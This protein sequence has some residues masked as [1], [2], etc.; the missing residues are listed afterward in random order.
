MNECSSRSHLVVRLHIESRPVD[1]SSTGLCTCVHRQAYTDCIINKH[2][3]H[4]S[5]PCLCTLTQPVTHLLTD[6]STPTAASTPTNYDLIPASHDVRPVLVAVLDFVDLAGAEQVGKEA[7]R[8]G[9]GDRQRHVE[10]LLR[11][12]GGVGIWVGIGW[13]GYVYQLRVC[14]DNQRPPMYWVYMSSGV[15]VVCVRLTATAHV[16]RPECVVFP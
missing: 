9:A 14:C 12:M 1:P 7:S 3:H 10:V 13:G 11:C 5:I 15:Y 4:V 16:W 6:T 8:E 2:T